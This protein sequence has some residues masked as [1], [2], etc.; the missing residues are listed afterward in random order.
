MA[1]FVIGKYGE[2]LMPTERYG[3]VRRMLKDGRA[4]IYKRNPFTIQLT[5]ETTSYIQPIEICVDTGYK[6]VGISIKSEAK[7]YV[8]EQRD[9]LDDEK[10]RHDAQRKMRRTRRNRLRYRKPRFDN[11]RSSKKEGW[12][13]PSLRNK[14]DR[15]VDLIVNYASVCPI[16][17]VYLEVGEFDTMLLKAI[18]EG[19]P[20]PEG[21]DYQHG[22]Q[23]Q[24]E[25]LRKALF[26]RDHYTC[27]ICG[28]TIKDGAKLTDH[29]MYFWRDQ[30]G[31]SLDELLTVCELC[32]I[33]AN[34]QPGGK[35]F[36]L[37]KKLPRYVGP[38]FMNTVRWYMYHKV[39]EALPNM[40][41]HLVYGAGTSI[42]RKDLKLEKSHANDAYAMGKFHPVKRAEEKHYK[43]RRRNNRVLEKFYDAKYVDIRDGKPKSG[44]AL[45][46]QRTNRREAR[47]S[48]KNLRSYRGKKKSSGR[49]PIRRTRYTIRPGDTVLWR[50]NPYVVKGVHCN[51]KNVLFNSGKS[52]SIKQVSIKKHVNGWM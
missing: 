52:V 10:Q 38:A 6:Y 16:T 37:D 39:Q 28:R 32:H 19:K 8:S 7:E 40:D 23:Y 13:A 51:G 34:H 44:A 20:I 42:A 47:N 50:N 30:H 5:Y 22:P 31:D 46:C 43:K 45:G 12:I 33:P 18:Q 27:Q 2:R 35:L 26:Q 15:H 1:V 29:H 48:E 36:G 41:M 4:V 14:A 49:R 9:L 11:R 21:T 17:S 3:V 24:H 25:T